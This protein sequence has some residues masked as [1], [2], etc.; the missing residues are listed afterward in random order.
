MVIPPAATIGEEREQREEALAASP[1][2]RAQG[3]RRGRNQAA[4]AR[5]S[6]TTR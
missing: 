2:Q 3:W 5:I 4:S 1:I 6:P